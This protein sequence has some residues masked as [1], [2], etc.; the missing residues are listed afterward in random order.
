MNSKKHQVTKKIQ[1]LVD[2]ASHL[3]KA[4]HYLQDDYSE[5]PGTYDGTTHWSHMTVLS[6]KTKNQFVYIKG[7]PGR[8]EYKFEKRY[9]CNKK[10]EFACGGLTDVTYALRLIIKTYKKFLG[11]DVNLLEND[12]SDPYQYLCDRAMAEHQAQEFEKYASMHS[13]V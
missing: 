8:Y 1:K 13:L 5:L 12:Y 7:A 11:F 2:H 9:N 10:D 4:Y 6:V 3:V